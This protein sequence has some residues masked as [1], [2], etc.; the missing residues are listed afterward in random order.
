MKESEKL[1][2]EYIKKVKKR[3]NDHGGINNVED[4]WGE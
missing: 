4:R 2:K 1:H 3:I